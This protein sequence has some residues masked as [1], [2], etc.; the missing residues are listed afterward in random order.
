[1][2]HRH[3]ALFPERL[4]FLAERTYGKAWS[5]KGTRVASEALANAT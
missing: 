2:L 5:V 4:L 1:M 3:S